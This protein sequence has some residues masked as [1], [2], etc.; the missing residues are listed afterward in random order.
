MYFPEHFAYKIMRNFFLEHEEY[1]YLVLATDDIVVKPEHII[2]LTR[3][4]EK[5]APA[6][7]S[8]VMNVDLDDQVFVNLCM[9][10]PM[11]HRRQRKYPWMTRREVFVEEDIFQVAFSGFPLMAIRRDVVKK[12]PFDADKV[13]EGMAGDK[14]ASLD[15]VFCQYCMDRDIPILVDKRIDML[16]LRT[17]GGLVINDK[18]KVVK[19]YKGGMPGEDIDYEPFR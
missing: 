1:D 2:Q 4:L 16:H 7:L 3:D 13:F 8:G 18:A 19:Y 17:K 5:R 15:F 9:S 12:L 10:L 6:V 11:K 14:G